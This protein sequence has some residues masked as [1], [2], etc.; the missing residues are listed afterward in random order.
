MYLNIGSDMAVR[1]RSIIGIFDLDHATIG[2]DSRAFLKS[3][4]DACEVVDVSDNLP[5]TFLVTEEYGMH[6]AYLTQPNAAT[7]EK[8]F[9]AAAR[10]AR[11]AQP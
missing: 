4:Q 8:R 11:D 5:K 3:A 1:D 2:K 10:P 6:R 7:M 9:R